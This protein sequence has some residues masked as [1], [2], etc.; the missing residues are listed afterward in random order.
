MV[1]GETIRV[2][3]D[4]GVIGSR[5]LVLVATGIIEISAMLDAA[6]H[7]GSTAPFT[8]AQVGAGANSSECDPGTFPTPNASSGCGGA[9]GSFGT[10]GGRG[11]DGIGTD[12]KR[13][14]PGRRRPPPPCA[15]AALGRGAPTR[16]TAKAVA[17]VALS[18]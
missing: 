11:G 4:V 17:V 16:T 12:G 14:N 8:T 7:N 10:R 13:G 2:Q 6:S 3:Q 15:A 5:P 1:E 18:I 9:G